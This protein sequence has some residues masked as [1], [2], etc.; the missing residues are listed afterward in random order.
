MYDPIQCDENEAYYKFDINS[1][2][3]ACIDLKDVKEVH[4]IKLPNE[5]AAFV[6][7]EDDRTCYLYDYYIQMIVTTVNGKVLQ[8]MLKPKTVNEAKINFEDV[9]EPEKKT[10][11][12]QKYKSYL[13][14]THEKKQKDLK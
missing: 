7:N 1:K 8:K 6:G 4:I 3:Q 9:N 12:F 14:E 5:T 10:E 11:E 2:F 13:E